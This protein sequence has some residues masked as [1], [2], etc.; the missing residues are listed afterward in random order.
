MGRCDSSI[1]QA[2][3]CTV[4]TS[5]AREH[6]AYSIGSTSGVKGSLTM[7]G[8]LNFELIDSQHSREIRVT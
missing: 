5:W 3:L 7:N 8:I 1:C 2:W 6:S 4:D